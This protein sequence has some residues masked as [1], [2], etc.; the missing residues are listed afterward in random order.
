VT[1][2]G[3][4]PVD[5]KNWLVDPER[6]LRTFLVLLAIFVVFYF[7]ELANFSLSIDEEYAIFS[8]GSDIWVQQDR[9]AIYLIERLFLAAPVIPFF[10][11]FLFG[12]FASLGYMILAGL[13][14]FRLD[15]WRVLLLFVLFAAFP[16]LHFILDFAIAGVPVGVGLLLCCL[17]I[18]LFD[19]AL[20]AIVAAEARS[21]RM[22]GLFVLQALLGATVTGI[23]QSLLLLTAA[24]CCGLF[25]LCYLRRPAM[26][27]RHILIVHLYLAGNLVAGALVGLLIARGF[28]WLLAVEPAYIAHFVKLDQFADSPFAV[29]RRTLREY[30]LVYGGK[31]AVYGYRYLTFPALLLLGMFALAARV[32]ERRAKSILFVVLYM[33]GITSIPFAINVVAGGKMPYR[34][35]VAVPYV[36]WFFAAAA[37]LSQI[38]IVRRIA[39]ALVILVAIQSLYTF[40]T[41]QAQKRLVQDHDRLLAS[42]LYERIVEAVPDFD[43]SKAYRLDVYGGHEFENAYQEIRSSTWSASFFEWDGGS[44]SRILAFMKTLGFSNFE[45]IDQAARKA[46]LPTFREMPVWPA[47][48]SVRVVEGTILVRLGREPGTVHIRAKQAGGQP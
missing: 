29:L 6:W 25:L 20:Q 9:W 10:P 7:S 8:T 3:S 35:L 47:A 41:F 34:S 22:V 19:R 16:T 37:L 18:V 15:D 28:Q 38:A 44:P 43:R 24:G 11:L 30:W 48:G 21:G 32:R 39:I 42:Q 12:A 33:L 27:L 5:A 14:E 4:N 40:S 45:E 36:F 23:Y 31:R 46:F 13:H 2:L 26:T 17:S 1:L